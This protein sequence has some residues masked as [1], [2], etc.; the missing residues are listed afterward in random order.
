[1][2]E[3]RASNS[4]HRSTKQAIMCCIVRTQNMCIQMQLQS[5]NFTCQI[6]RMGHA[7]WPSFEPAGSFNWAIGTPCLYGVCTSILNQVPRKKKYSQPGKGDIFLS[8]V[9]QMLCCISNMGLPAKPRSYI[10][11]TYWN[12]RRI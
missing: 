10:R 5:T 2:P 8:C 7:P 6:P 1:V 3:N 12:E 11:S 4:V 9:L